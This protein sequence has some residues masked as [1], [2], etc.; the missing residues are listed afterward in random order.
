MSFDTLLKFNVISLNEG[1]AVPLETMVG[2]ALHQ[3]RDL[4]RIEQ[5]AGPTG[6]EPDVVLLERSEF[7]RIYNALKGH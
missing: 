2:H 1:G 3:G 7:D 5:A 4:V 6:G